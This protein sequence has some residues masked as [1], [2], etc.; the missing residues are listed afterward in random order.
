MKAGL[1]F[2]IEESFIYL[3]S[4]AF[5]FLL[6]SDCCQAEVGAGACEQH[7]CLSS[8]WHLLMKNNHGELVAPGPGQ[9]RGPPFLLLCYSLSDSAKLQVLYMALVFGAK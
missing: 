6:K 3:L 4:E 7:M 2:F 8:M 1:R 5:W 9:R